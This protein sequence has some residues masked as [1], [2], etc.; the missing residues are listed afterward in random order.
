MESSAAATRHKFSVGELEKAPGIL[1][2]TPKAFLPNL[3]DLRVHVSSSSL[4]LCLS[5]AQ[6]YACCWG[7]SKSKAP[8]VS[9]LGIDLPMAGLGIQP[10]AS[11]APGK[12]F[13]TELHPWGSPS[14]VDYWILK[15]PDF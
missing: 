2:L 5:G 3:W 12:R 13:T 9:L 6:G 4:W 15:E 7:S 8:L 11:L 10:R 1:D 14:P